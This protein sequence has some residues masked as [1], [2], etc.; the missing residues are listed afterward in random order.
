[1]L[2]PSRRPMAHRVFLVVLALAAATIPFIASP[3][4]SAAETVWVEAWRHETSRP[5]TALAFGDVT[6]DGG[7]DIVTLNDRS[8]IV[9]ALEE[10]GPR[11][12]ASI[13]EIAEVPTA[14]AVAP[15]DG[16][17]PPAIWIGTENPGIVYVYTYDT[18]SR[19]FV[20]RER[21]RYAWADVQRL[22]PLDLDGSGFRDLAVVTRREE[23]LL[24]RWTPGGYEP[25]PL[26]DYGRLIRFVEARDVDGDHRDELVVARDANH[27][28]VLSWQEAVEA[29][30]GEEEFEA[31]EPRARLVNLWENYIW[32][33]H[34][35]LFVDTFRRN[36]PAEIIA[37]SSQR[38]AHHF[39]VVSGDLGPVRT[40]VEWPG[41]FGRMVGAFD[42]DDDGIAEIVEAT[43]SGLA[44]WS[45]S[46]RVSQK[47]S[48]ELARTP[49]YALARDPGSE[50]LVVGGPWGFS[51]FKEVD[52][53]YVNVV[54]RGVAYE[55]IRPTLFI[56]GM[57]YL[58]AADW[59]ELLKI[60]LRFDSESKQISGLKGFHFLVGRLGE[61]QW[62]YDGRPKQTAAPPIIHDGRLYLS[63][64]FAQVVGAAIVWEPFTRTLVVDP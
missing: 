35:A 11:F 46:S 49:V 27:L 44:L 7:M 13:E 57:A 8:V 52:A 2:H 42:L 18:G 14:V 16:E 53:H 34:L 54:T 63:A 15:Y 48:L 31:L 51:V 59:E 6:G 36:Q 62:V 12:V 43:R 30:G 24:Y 3:G 40:A 20:R 32:G 41:V 60:R 9:Y 50:R 25:V 39:G 33:T 21:I 55:T 61:T 26:G 4:I 45:V 23:L 56:D 38:M 10:E 64:D 17:D 29:R 19:R 58:S 28:V 22:I 47:G 1:M 37:I 5:L